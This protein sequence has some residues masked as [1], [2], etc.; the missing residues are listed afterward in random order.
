MKENKEKYGEVFTPSWLVQWMIDDAKQLM[1]DEFFHR[2]IFKPGAGLGVFYQTL[3][4]CYNSYHERN[5]SPE[6]NSFV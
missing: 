2:N 1:G 3:D 6:T 5:Q 4:C